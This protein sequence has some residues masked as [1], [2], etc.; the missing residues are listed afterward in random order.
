MNEGYT[1]QNA[2]RLYLMRR[3]ELYKA[4]RMRAESSQANDL[5]ISIQI[6]GCFHMILNHR[7]DMAF[8]KKMKD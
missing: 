2:S 6:R 8:Q 3:H 5:K 7:I 4:S 1:P